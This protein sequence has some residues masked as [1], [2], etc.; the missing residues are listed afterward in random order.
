MRSLDRARCGGAQPRLQRCV[1]DEAA[2]RVAKRG[3]VSCARAGRLRRSA[4]TSGTPP[5]AV[6]ITGVRRRVPRRPC[7]ES[8]PGRRQKCG[9]GRGE[10]LEHAGPRHGPRKRDA[11]GDAELRGVRL[12]GAR[13]SPSP[14][15]RNVTPSFAASASSA[16][17]SDFCAVQPSGERERRAV[18]L[19]LAAQLF[20]RPERRHGRRGVREHRHAPGRNTPGHDELAQVRTRREDVRGPPQLRVAGDTERANRDIAARVLEFVHVAT[21]EAPPPRALERG[22]GG[23][24]HD[25]RP[26]RRRRARRTAPEHAGRVDDVGPPCATRDLGRRPHVDHPL[27]QRPG[28]PVHGILLRCGRNPRS[29]HD[30]DLVPVRAQERGHVG[31]MARRAADVRAARFRRRR[32]LIARI[33]AL[34]SSS[35]DISARSAGSARPRPDPHEDRARR[36]AKTTMPARKAPAAPVAP[37]RPEHDHEPEHDSVSRPCVQS[38]SFCRP[39]VTGNDWSSRR[40]APRQ[41]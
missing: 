28:D 10:D 4:T 37:T 18:E 12:S 35:A 23:Q 40:R 24:L 13:S 39:I 29:R 14:A 20:P 31:R 17:P 33:P 34:V 8:S 36:S 7:A 27:G 32:E 38:R 2:D 5:T 15:I 21:D 26:P 6:A 11:A 41:R 25:V 30:L 22:V 19:E 1:G 9:V 16:T 3:R